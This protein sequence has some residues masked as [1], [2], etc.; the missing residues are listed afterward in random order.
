MNKEIFFNTDYKPNES[1][2]SQ[3]E[4]L[5]QNN[6]SLDGIQ[7]KF[8]NMQN[9]KLV[10]ASLKNSDLTRS[11]F[12]NSSLYNAN[13]EG[14]NLFKTN[15]EGAN[16]KSA[17]M[18]NCNMLGA[19]F[20]NSKLNNI[21]W[22]KNHK[23]INE[24]Q[25]EKA[26]S[27]GEQNLAHEKYKEAED[28]YRALRISLQAQSLGDDVGKMFVRELICKRKQLSKFSP[29][30]II[31]K[32]AHITTGYGE[33]VGNIFYTVLAILIGCAVLYGLA[34]VSYGNKI[35]GFFGDVEHFGGMLNVIGNLFYFSVVVFSTVGFGEIVPVNALGKSIMI[36]EGM[37]G[38][39][40]MS[41]LIIAVYRQLMDR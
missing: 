9:S 24:I 16:L 18:K 40:I 14:A 13:F 38:G 19:D 10:N 4:T 1:T 17:N 28:I 22:G 29:M 8:A 41:I 37:T 6:E 12:S 33:K 3:I 36:F 30:R 21:D 2:K 34:G 27:N 7:L 32:I 5:H 11:D 23:L 35:L 39:I 20:S 15:F 25:A 31:S 26:I